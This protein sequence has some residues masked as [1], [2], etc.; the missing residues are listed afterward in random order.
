MTTSACAIPRHS[1]APMNALIRIFIFHPVVSRQVD[2]QCS[3]RGLDDHRWLPPAKPHRLS[4]H[5]P[6]PRSLV[7]YKPSQ[8]EAPHA[9]ESVEAQEKAPRNQNQEQLALG[10]C[11][12][13]SVLSCG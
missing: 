7:G 5:A 10:G 6:W 3:E 9:F 2:G 11:V 13:V 4:P 8:Q 1:A 12:K